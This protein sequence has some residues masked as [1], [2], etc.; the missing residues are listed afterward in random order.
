MGLGADIFVE[1]LGRSLSFL[2]IYGSYLDITHFWEGL[3][4]NSSSN[5]DEVILGGDLNFALGVVEVWGPKVV[6]DP[7]TDFFS[8]MLYGRVLLDI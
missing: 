4:K 7:F 3:L 5:L 2:N 6:A 8:Y 1:E